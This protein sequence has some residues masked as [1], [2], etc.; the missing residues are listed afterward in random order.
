MASACKRGDDEPPPAQSDT[1]A[2]VDTTTSGDETEGADPPQS[3]GRFFDLERVYDISI[4]MD[5]ADWDALRHQSRDYEHILGDE[6]AGCFTSPFPKPFT[7]FS[8]DVTVDGFPLAPVGVR[9]KGFG[10]MDDE[11]PALKLKFHHFDQDLEL[12]GMK[13]MTLNN[14]E[15]DPSKV[16]QCISYG[17]YAAAGVPAPRCSYVHVYVNGQDLGLYVNVEPIKKPFLAQHFESDEG[18]LYEGHESDFRP[19]LTGTF[20][21]KTNESDP[22]RLD[23]G[24]V[25][26][27]AA[28]PDDDLIP[29]L[30]AV[31]DLDRFYAYWAVEVLINNDD[32]YPQNKNNFWIYGDQD[33]RF[34][35]I[36]WGVDGTLFWGSDGGTLASVKANARLA[37]R[38]YLHPEGRAAY[39]DRLR[40]LLAT[41]WDEDALVT[42]FDRQAALVAPHIDPDEEELVEFAQGIKR[43]F[44]LTQ[45][46]RVEAD[47]AAEP[48]W[49]IDEY[50]ALCIVDRGTLDVTF[51]ATV[52]SADQPPAPGEATVMPMLDG[53]P[54]DVTDATAEAVDPGG[55]SPVTLTFRGTY[56]EGVLATQVEV[57]RDALQAGAQIRVDDWEDAKGL[58]VR[59]GEAGNFDYVGFL[60]QGTLSIDAWD[61]EGSPEPLV[62]SLHARVIGRMCGAD[63]CIEDIEFARGQ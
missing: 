38:L 61:G 26:T 56:G 55:Y 20:D 30:D 32:G 41:V 51:E 11:R 21:K 45:R 46:A 34:T 22:S 63:Q 36:P 31:V 2:A 23:L 52:G 44:L 27:A 7:W 29:A 3:D 35:F 18:N 9:K 28:V 62:G 5:E 14:A 50:S 25:V 40:E 39:E 49:E 53:E 43:D 33:G 37:R 12:G 59:L 58:V 47:L 42:E 16:G 57:D 10:S 4:V 24:A 19:T 1:T 60:H 54:W 8:A 17:I 13:R 15:Q 48:Q 6:G